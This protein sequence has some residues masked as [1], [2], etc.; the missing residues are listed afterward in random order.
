M[1]HVGLAI[2][3]ATHNYGLHGERHHQIACRNFVN[4]PRAAP[5]DFTQ[6]CLCRC[7]THCLGCKAHVVTHTKFLQIA[8]AECGVVVVVSQFAHWVATLFRHRSRSNEV[9]RRRARGF[10]EQA[11]HAADTAVSPV[12]QQHEAHRGAVLVE[13][14]VV[15]PQRP[16]T[17][18]TRIFANLFHRLDNRAIFAVGILAFV[19]SEVPTGPAVDETVVGTRNTER[20]DS[21]AHAAILRRARSGEWQFL[22]TKTNDADGQKC[23]NHGGCNIETQTTARR[24]CERLLFFG[25]GHAGRG[26]LEAR[27]ASDCDHGFVDANHHEHVAQ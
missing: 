13:L 23:H 19:A 22:K 1:A 15:F 14:T 3:A 6:R 24:R 10:K 11:F 16:T 26:A 25:L 8:H 21:V 20:A 9:V 4:H 17:P 5:C 27:K 12:R 2:S 7:L 18:V